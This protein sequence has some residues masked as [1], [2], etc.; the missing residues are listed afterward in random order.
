MGRI[1]GGARD[2]LVEIGRFRYIK[3]WEEL[4]LDLT[5]PC[6]SYAHC[7]SAISRLQNIT[8]VI[9]YIKVQE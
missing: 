5:N 8:I 3:R 2:R 4:D 7:N 9:I 6:I 1:M